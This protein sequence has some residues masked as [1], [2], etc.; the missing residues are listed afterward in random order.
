MPAGP[1]V[2]LSELAEDRLSRAVAGLPSLV[3]RM[4]HLFGHRLRVDLPDVL[5]WL[6]R[7]LPRASWKFWR[8]KV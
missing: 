2:D 6:C 7:R 5:L 1:Q 3:E 8:G 4:A